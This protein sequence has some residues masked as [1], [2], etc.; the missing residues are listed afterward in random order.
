MN[1]TVLRQK[2]TAQWSRLTPFT[3]RVQRD[4]PP[5]FARIRSEEEEVG[6]AMKEIE[7]R[8]LQIGTTLESITTTGRD[9]VAHCE[10]LI[11]LALGQ[12]GGELMIE[13]A[14]K[15][16]WRAVDFVEK[17]DRNMEEL[18]GR[19]NNSNERISQ[20]LATEQV[21]L[22]TLAPLNFVKTLF[23]V[24]AA[25]LS[26]DVQDMFCALAHEIDRIRLR[27]EGGF[28][29]KFQLIR[30]IQAILGKSIAHLLK[31]QSLAKKS[32]AG[33]RQHMTDSLAAMKVSYEKNR[34][35][36]TRLSGVS[37]AMNNETGRVVM[38]LQSQD[39]LTQKLQHIRTVL[40]EMES[41]FDSLPQERSG[42][43]TSLHFIEQSGRIAVAQLTSMAEELT[44]AGQTIGDGLH[45]IIGQMEALDSNCLALRDLDTV[46]TG[47][48]GAVQILLDSVADVQQLMKTADHQ[49][50]EAHETIA[51]IGGMTMNFTSFIRELSLEIQLIGLNAEVQAAHVGQGTGLEILSAHTSSISRETRELSE[52]LA[53][54]LD[55]LTSGLDKVVASFR[56]I[57]EDNVSFSR[58][59]FGEFDQDTKAL[60]DYRNSSLK[61]LTQVS[62]L[63]PRL[64]TQTRLA[65]EQVDFASVASAPLTALKAA[66]AT[67]ADTAFA[68]AH[69]AGVKVETKGLTDHQ[70][71]RYTMRSEVDIHLQT[72]TG[73]SKNVSAPAEATT[74]KHDDIELFDSVSDPAL[75]SA[76]TTPPVPQAKPPVATP[77][78]TA[79]AN[80]ELW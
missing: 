43:C 38:S 37:Q 41:R 67:L 13:N 75:S 49:A 9:L 33:L 18:I 59:L 2:M 80:I 71:G 30:E 61:T 24:E 60:H 70:I 31:E 11:T 64:E 16:I 78:T 48:D 14:A 3:K 55:S 35:R 42:A 7:E 36:D 22:R 74:L 34:D 54:D 44:K 19:L 27:V 23:R 65:L 63:L 4:L 46:T 5:C 26:P 58:E 66:V 8:F 69:Q 29:E 20:T 21:L 17:N 73:K 50:K 47:V 28:R 68:A 52:A 12:G 25:G 15:H 51:P 77:P 62:E 57:R 39:I 76:P 53:K 45:Q 56:D 32:V 40:A 1:S 6:L 79:D 72:L 10:S